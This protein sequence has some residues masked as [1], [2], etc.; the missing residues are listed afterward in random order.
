MSAVEL[1]VMIRFK[2]DELREEEEIERKHE[3]PSGISAF[4]NE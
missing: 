3:N 1:I 4:K 2:K